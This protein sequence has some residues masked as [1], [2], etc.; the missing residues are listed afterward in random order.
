MINQLFIKYQLI[1]IDN[2]NSI[3]LIFSKSI[4]VGSGV[5]K[6]HACK[7]LLVMSSHGDLKVNACDAYNS[8]YFINSTIS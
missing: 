6:S 5:S 4:L 2:P 7:L 8:L 3:R 1:V